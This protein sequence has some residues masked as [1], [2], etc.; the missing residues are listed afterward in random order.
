MRASDLL[1]DDGVQILGKRRKGNLAVSWTCPR[2]A[3]EFAQ[4]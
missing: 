4:P 1:L 2:N 3:S